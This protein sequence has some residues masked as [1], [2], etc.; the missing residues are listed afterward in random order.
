MRS[1][2]PAACWSL[3]LLTFSGA[4]VAAE[5]HGVSVWLDKMAKA[6]REQSY[7][8]TFTYMRGYQFD[9]VK[10]VHEFREGRE[11]ERLL[12]LNGEQREV[13][14][15]GD[16]VVCRHEKS[17]SPDLDHAMLFGP[18]TRT[19]NE[20]LA[21]YSALYEVGLAGTDRV[22]GRAT[23]ILDIT[24][25]NK[26]RYGYRL[27]LDKATGLLLQSHLID[28]GSIREVFQFSQINIGET[29]DPTHFLSSMSD[30]LIEH[31]INSAEFQVA[32]SS[33]RP[34]WRVAWL[35][36]GFRQ[37]SSQGPNRTLYSD[38]IATLS[39]FIE[40]GSSAP[41]GEVVSYMGGTVLITRRVKD[42]SQQITVVGEI[43]VDTAK[44]VAESIEPVL[45]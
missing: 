19:F 41:L 2:I 4:V 39:V 38:G 28:R 17:D 9:T 36:K 25:K 18:F 12:H 5:Q 16:N 42:S 26:D 14:R 43:P 13:I 33:E 7:E 40:D 29:V 20:N 11:V 32:E 45:Y 1:A 15:D 24:P 27:W 30:N 44:R 23:V 8:G 22:A 6:L 34:D 3:L 35:P 21:N 37:I 31:H 10:V